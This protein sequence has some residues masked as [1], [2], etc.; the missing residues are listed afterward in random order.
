M[1]IPGSPQFPLNLSLSSLKDLSLTIQYP[2][3][4]ILYFAGAN[5]RNVKKME[6]KQVKAGRVTCHPRDKVNPFC[7]FT[8]THLKV[9]GFKILRKSFTD[10][11]I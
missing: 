9:A 8:R 11:G 4:A 10:Y 1:R 5:A 2:P 7:I 6:I 3:K